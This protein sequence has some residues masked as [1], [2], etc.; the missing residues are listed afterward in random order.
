MD[1]ENAAIPIDE[2]LMQEAE[3]V[4]ETLEIV[5]V[6]IAEEAPSDFMPFAVG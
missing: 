2:A 1:A 6:P 3:H 4:L 5:P